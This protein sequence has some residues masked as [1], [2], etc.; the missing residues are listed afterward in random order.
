MTDA[1][2]IN[3]KYLVKIMFVS[4]ILILIG[5]FTE[6]IS[7]FSKTLVQTFSPPKEISPLVINNS[8]LSRIVKELNVDEN[9]VLILKK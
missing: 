6:N 4:F 9:S 1:K 2:I 5:V 7:F 3:S 8:S